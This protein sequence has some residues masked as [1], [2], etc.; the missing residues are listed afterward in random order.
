VLVEQQP[1][2]AAVSGRLVGEQLLHPRA[3]PA[4]RGAALRRITSGASGRPGPISSPTASC[5]LP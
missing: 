2:A 1:A 3:Q 4:E 5:T